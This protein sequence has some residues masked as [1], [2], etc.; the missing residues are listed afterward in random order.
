MVV[1]GLNLDVIE[2]PRKARFPFIEYSLRKSKCC[3]VLN[4]PGRDDGPNSRKEIVVVCALNELRQRN[5]ARYFTQECRGLLD[6]HA[7]R[8]G[9]NPFHHIVHQGHYAV[10]L[11]SE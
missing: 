2:A 3:K 1:D 7:E 8:L 9:A 5:A 10:M 6:A 4:N 11:T